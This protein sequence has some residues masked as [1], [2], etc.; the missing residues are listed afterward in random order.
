LRPNRL[1]SRSSETASELIVARHGPVEIRQTL[2]GWVLETCVKGEPDR[3]RATA[4]QRLS[5]YANGKNRSGRRLRAA[6]PLV[7]TEESTGRWRLRIALPWIDSDFVAAAGRNGRVRLRA[8]DSETL[9]VLRV[10]GRPTPRAI[11]HAATA[12]RHAIAATRWEPTGG[13][14]LRLHAQPTVLLHLGRFEVALPVAERGSAIS[15]WMSP[16]AN[17]SAAQEAATQ[18]SPPTH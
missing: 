13:V 9:A 18:S 16:M 17:R 1:L 6:R 3:A 7:Q 15:N 5:A 4:L 10:P 14:M 11:E 12:I 8:L 2:A